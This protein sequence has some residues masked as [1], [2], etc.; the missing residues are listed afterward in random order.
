MSVPLIV[1][2]VTYNYPQQFDKNWAPTLTNW[3]TAVTNGML[4]KAGGTFTLTADVNFGAS[5]GLLSKYFTTRTASPATAGLLRLA[6]TDTIEWR[7][8]AGAADNILAINGS[9][10]LI[11]NT[12]LVAIQGSTPTF[13]GMVS[14]GLIELRLQNAIQFDDA[15]GT[16]NAEIAAPT[17]ISTS[18]VMTMPTADAGI[19]SIVCP[20]T[21]W[22][23]F[24]P[25]FT[26]SGASDPVIGNGSLQGYWRRVG[27]TMEV[28]ASFYSGTTTTYGDAGGQ[29]LFTLP[30]GVSFASGKMPIDGNRTWVG[31]FSFF[32]GAGTVVTPGAVVVYSATAVAFITSIAA[33]AFLSGSTAIFW[34]AAT[35]ANSLEFKLSFPVT[36]WGI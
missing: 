34:T 33:A 22:I 29:I 16:H 27:D 14:N 36:D 35:A 20:T 32:N 1:N 6:K 30:L 25:T 15:A 13:A 17:S 12:A 4:Q 28:S 8:N 19:T 23:A 21:N 18:Y 11:Y 24:T 3:S 2:G 9:D 31:G 10:K 5:F 7:N 26:T